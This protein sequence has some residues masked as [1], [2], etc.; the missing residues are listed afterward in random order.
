MRAGVSSYDVRTQVWSKLPEGE[1]EEGIID[2]DGTLAPTL[3]E[4]K[5][6]MDISYKGIWGYHPL[7]ITLANTNEPLYL[8]NRPG[9]VVSHQ[10]CAPWIDKAIDLVGAHAKR[11]LVRGDTDFSLTEHFDRWSEKA[12]FVFG[13]DA[14][15]SFVDRADA[16]KAS[17]WSPL[18]RKPKHEVK[19]KGRRKPENVKERIVVER[20][21]ENIRLN[22]EEVAE[23]AYKP[24]KCKKTY[25]MVV[26]KKNITREKGELAL[27]D[28]I[29]YFF[30]V[31]TRHD[32]TAREVVEH[33]N[34]RCN[35]EN[36][37]EQIKNGV[38]AMRMPVDNLT[39]NWAYMVMAT[40]AWS[41]K[42]WLGILSSNKE[43]GTQ[44]IKMEFRRFLNTF[45]L[46]PCQV[47]ST[48]RKIVYRL[49]G[50]NEK[51]LDLFHTFERI[52]HLQFE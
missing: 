51:L 13:I 37:I 44:I 47:I 10:D 49:L 2:V 32:L 6:G 36:T 19:T 25:R 34:K 20:K 41:L 35:Q 46:I 27:L 22:S 16:L 18:E 30:Y 42:A 52:R 43:L 45:I 17:D 23:F 28:D 15:R 12:D 48:G 9:N 50:Y 26:V 5:E 24:G 40:L 29:R 14:H 31:T 3:G 21:Y 33:A 39:S 7:I 8:V 38:N 4:C 1:M 11:V